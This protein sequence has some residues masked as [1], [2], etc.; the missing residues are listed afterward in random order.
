MEVTLEQ[1]LQ[2]GIEA[3]QAGQVEEADRL[4]T[5]IL[6]TDPKH[7]DANHNLGVLAVG[8]GKV[9]AALPFFKTALDSNSNI[10]QYWLSYIDALIKLGR[11][12]N[13]KAILDQAKRQIVNGECFYQIEKWLYSSESKGSKTEKITEEKVQSLITLYADGQ[14]QEVQTKACELLKQFPND[15]SLYNISGAAFHKLGKLTNALEAYQKAIVLKPDYADS[16]NNLGVALKNYGKFE[17]ALESYT[18]AIT[19][20]PNFAE[21]YYNMGKALQD[22]GKFDDAV[23]AFEKAISIKPKYAEAYYS[24]GVALRSH[25]QLEASIKA[26]KKALSIKPGYTE[27]MINMGNVFVKLGKPKEA[28]EALTSAIAKSPDHANAYNNM[29][30]ALQVQSK[31]EESLEC[32]KKAISIKPDHA[33]AYTNMGET[34][35]RQ[36]KLKNSIASFKKA[37]SIKG[38]FANAYWN[39]YGTSNNISEATNWLIKCLDANPNHLEAKLTL[40]ALQFLEGDKCNFRALLKTS[41]KDHPYIRSFNWAFKLPTMPRLYYHR[42]ALF[43]YVISESKKDRPFYEFGVWRGE[44]FKHLIKAFKKGYGFDS[45]E[46][47]PDDWHN[48]NAGAYTSNGKVPKIKGGKFIVGQFEDTLPS[49]FAEPRPVASVINFDADLYSSTICALNNAKP[50]ID[51]HTILVFDE[52]IINEHWEEDEYKALEEFCASN[53]YTY[54]VLA[55][56]FF[57]K[58]VAVRIIGV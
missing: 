5:A 45:F 34:F 38:D 21:A 58:Q 29:G 17:E 2:K 22:L 37:I 9:E 1:A 54:E 44:A 46:G 56:S 43:D 27:A 18:T 26:Y 28:I 57:T 35:Q 12:D 7:A 6:K 3:H 33:D 51:R 39:L 41:S 40:S 13:A 42:W 19:L 48:E 4:Y 8:V 10:A 11:T 36:G 25:N 52:F 53:Q 32:F 50:V 20:K 24:M 16:H 15:V 47:L 31:L 49:F 23:V 14:Y 55:I 30:V